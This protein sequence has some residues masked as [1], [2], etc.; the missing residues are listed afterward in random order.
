MVSR[1]PLWLST[2]LLTSLNK[3]RMKVL[4]CVSLI[5]EPIKPTICVSTL[6]KVL[7]A[8]ARISA[9]NLRHSTTQSCQSVIRPMTEVESETAQHEISFNRKYN[10]SDVV[11][12]PKSIGVGDGK[13]R[14]EVG[15]VPP[16]KR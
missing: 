11:S 6:Q 15:D 13:G 1:T 4:K 12:R 2:G 7:A 9:M 10:V 5:T 14:A 8:I 16:P 3:W